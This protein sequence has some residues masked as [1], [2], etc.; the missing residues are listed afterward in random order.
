MQFPTTGALAGLEDLPGV[1]PKRRFYPRAPAGA[2]RPAPILVPFPADTAPAAVGAP[3]AQ[4]MNRNVPFPRFDIAPARGGG[5]YN[6]GEQIQDTITSNL[7][8][9]FSSLLKMGRRRLLQGPPQQG[10]PRQAPPQQGPPQQ[11]GPRYQ[12]APPNNQGP[13]PPLDPNAKVIG[14]SPELDV[15]Y[16]KGTAT[17]NGGSLSFAGHDVPIP[18]L[19]GV[20]L[21]AEPV[22]T[23]LRLIRDPTVLAMDRVKQG[24]APAPAEDAET[25]AAAA[26]APAPA[27]QLAALALAPASQLAYVGA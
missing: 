9:A 2:P 18:D 1:R 20:E 11:G 4:P 26:S 22:L 5:V 27:S 15:N 19:S 8:N 23:V 10:P 6:P 13:P 16:E 12:Q 7:G 21:P 3:S 25:A 14:V 17:I 24:L